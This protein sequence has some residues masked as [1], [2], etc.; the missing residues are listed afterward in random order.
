MSHRLDYDAVL[1]IRDDVALEELEGVVEEK[2]GEYFDEWFIDHKNR[3][4]TF[5]GIAVATDVMGFVKEFL[6]ALCTIAPYIC[7]EEDTYVMDFD[8][9]WPTGWRMVFK[10]GNVK[11]YEGMMV[12]IDEVKDF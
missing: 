10:D 12:F 3:T 8:A 5:N 7:D 6:D 4:L 11:C 2:V 1:N 9:G